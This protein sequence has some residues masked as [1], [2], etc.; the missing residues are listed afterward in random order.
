MEISAEND[1]TD[2]KKRQWH[3]ERER[4]VKGHKL[5]TITSSKYLGAVL[6]EKWLKTRD[7]LK[8]C[9]S[10]CSSHKAETQLER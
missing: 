2:D 6:S 7:S 5:G 4:K 9:T 1:Q 8:D 3:P 10:H